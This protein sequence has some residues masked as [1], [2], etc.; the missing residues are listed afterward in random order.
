M[1]VLQCLDLLEDELDRL[2][3][4]TLAQD[5][6]GRGPVRRRVLGR[7][8]RGRVVAGPRGLGG[9]E[10]GGERHGR[11]EEE[12]ARDRAV[13]AVKKKAKSALDQAEDFFFGKDDDA[14]AGAPEAPVERGG[15]LKRAREGA[16]R[17][18]DE[19][20]GLVAFLVSDHAAYVSGQ[21]ISINGAMC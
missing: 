14:G 15:D 7:G 1:L 17:R 4:V 10:R 18:A 13:D 12:H 21:V 9:R 3:G 2:G 8:A 20:A 16:D 6:G 19:V 11:D 5:H